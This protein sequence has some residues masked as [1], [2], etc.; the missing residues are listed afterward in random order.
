MYA[1]DVTKGQT[2]LDYA[3]MFL[4]KHSNISLRRHIANNL[5]RIRG[6]NFTFY[7]NY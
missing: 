2:G 5:A 1:F 7:K 6:F 3:E 4:V